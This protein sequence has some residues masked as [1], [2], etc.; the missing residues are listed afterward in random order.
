MRTDTFSSAKERGRMCRESLPPVMSPITSI[1]RPSPRQDRGARPH[2]MPRNIWRPSN[3][4]HSFP[5]RERSLRSRARPHAVDPFV[6]VCD[7]TQFYSPP[8]GGVRRY[9]SEKV[10]F[11]REHTPD[12]EHV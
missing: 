9:L 10:R 2:S 6:K 7:L 1:V 12:D 5:G 11:I 4:P 3:E 8:S